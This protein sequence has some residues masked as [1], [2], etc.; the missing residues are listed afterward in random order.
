MRAP[1]TPLRTVV[2][3]PLEARVVLG[4]GALEGARLLVA[5]LEVPQPR[6]PHDLVVEALVGALRLVA[7]LQVAAVRRALGAVVP[8]VV[9]DGVE[10]P[11]GGGQAA[12]SC[13]PAAALAPAAQQRRNSP[14]LQVV[15]L[16]RL[17]A[18]DLG[19]V[20]GDDR[21]RLV[22]DRV[23]PRISIL[24]LGWR[25]GLALRAVAPHR[26]HDG[27]SHLRDLRC[28]INC[29]GTELGLHSIGASP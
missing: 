7:Q 2:E 10:V 14:L 5:T 23:E 1:P 8:L 3:D 11:A 22:A 20:G 16:E 19:E 26:V 6:H 29:K 4:H 15:L 27:P 9:R 25:R 13:A 24:L 12:H 21:R 17:D 18:M 28:S